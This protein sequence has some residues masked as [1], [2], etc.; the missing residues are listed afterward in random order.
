[1]CAVA[2]VVQV[3]WLIIA[4][5]MA[6]VRTISA[7]LRLERGFGFADRATQPAYHLG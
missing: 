7:G 2:G 6:A 5:M 3:G 1:M 4:M